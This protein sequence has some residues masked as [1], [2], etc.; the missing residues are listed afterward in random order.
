[1]NRVNAPDDKTAAQFRN[2]HSHPRDHGSINGGALKKLPSAFDPKHSIN[3][4][5]GAHD[6][7]IHRTTN[8]ERHKLTYE[9]QK[10]Q[11]KSPG[12]NG[13]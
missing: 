5:L 11:G 10:L 2:Q 8:T 7:S 9:S 1:M 3:V 4:E 13:G 6:W 12:A